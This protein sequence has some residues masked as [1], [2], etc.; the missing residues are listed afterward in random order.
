MIT[1]LII[2]IVF[3]IIGVIDEMVMSHV[4]QVMSMVNTEK[5]ND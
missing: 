3:M 4:G 1:I 5:Q 2:G